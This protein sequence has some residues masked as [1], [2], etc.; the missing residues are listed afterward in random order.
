MWSLLP[1]RPGWDASVRP[2]RGLMLTTSSP[3][4]G[5]TRRRRGDL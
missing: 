5:G 3:L 4:H 1:S 2:G